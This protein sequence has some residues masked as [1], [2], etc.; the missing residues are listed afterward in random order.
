MQPAAP[1]LGRVNVYIDGFNLYYGCLKT[2]PYKWLDLAKLCATLFPGEQ[3]G[4][5]RY[6]TAMVDATARNPGAPV[7]QAAYLRAL[8]TIPNLTIRLGHFLTERE[9]RL[10]VYPLN[11]ADPNVPNSAN[12]KRAVW[13]TE[14][15]GSDVNLATSLLLDAFAGDFERAWVFT[16]DSDLAWPIEMARMKFRRPVGV[17]MPNRPANYPDPPRTE[18]IQLKKAAR[19]FRKIEEGQL[20]ASQFPDTLT[21]PS[22]TI[23]KPPT[24]A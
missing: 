23:T 18:S 6:F 15:K 5:I 7:R 13:N 21:D 12:R 22:G 10:Q 3:I 11:P 4:L 17:M 16:N 19:W 8:R 14:E 9:D 1:R 24:W 20:A 2:T